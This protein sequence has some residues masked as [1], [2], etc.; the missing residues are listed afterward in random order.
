MST[1]P[2]GGV[3]YAAPAPKGS[4]TQAAEKPAPEAQPR[5]IIS[6]LFPEDQVEVSAQAAAREP[7]PVEEEQGPS[8][9]DQLV[10]RL[11]EIVAEAQSRA[12]SVRF[13]VELLDS[14]EVVIKVVNKESGDLVRQIPPDAIRNLVENL[15]ELRGLLFQEV[16]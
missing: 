1:A 14:G 3:G 8:A 11:S 4:K 6:T 10:E 13:Q 5:E 2:I 12:T 7:P 16:S 15:K 9:Q